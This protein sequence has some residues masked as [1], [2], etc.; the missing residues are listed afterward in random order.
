MN[1]V[2]DGRM[3]NHSGIG[4][5][6][7][8]L[9]TLLNDKSYSVVVLLSENDASKFSFKNLQVE[10]IEFGRYSWK[11]LLYLRKHI[12]N[13]D[14][15][16]C[17]F[18]SIPPVFS[19]VPVV[20]TVHDLCP[21]SE[22]KVFGTRVAIAYW[23]IMLLQLVVSRQVVTI[24]NFTRSEISKWF[25][26]LFDDKVSVVS[27]G[28]SVKEQP[29]HTKSTYPVDS[30]YILT[31]GNIKPHKNIMNLARTFLQSKWCTTHRLVIVGDHQGFR[32]KER[33]IMIDDSRIIFTGKIS[34]A[35]LDQLYQH[36]SLFVY[37]SF[38]EGF[39]LPLLE[40]MSYQ[41]PIACSSIP[42]FQEI[43]GDSVTYF[44]PH[45]LNSFWKNL[46]SFDSSN[47]YDEILNKYT[48]KAN[49]EKLLTI[50]KQSSSTGHQNLTHEG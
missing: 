3:I 32:T 38:Y 23:A 50:F 42:P 12:K 41:L 8:E 18:L 5:Y 37:P 25:C 1:I 47:H 29:N 33:D 15:Y 10:T 36:A 24:S 45:H 2:V 40:A 43:A 4:V 27:N 19:S 49:L 28:L 34:D 46:K 35:E 6:T 17:P 26:S 39:G 16:F 21:V 14:V 13:S 20:T 44:N 22:R 9:L 30:P 31:V 48:W 11:N 7:N